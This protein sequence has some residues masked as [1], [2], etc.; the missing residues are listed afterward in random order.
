MSEHP[1]LHPA[2]D[3]LLPWVVDYDPAL[4]DPVPPTTRLADE[5]AE[6]EVGA[7]FPDPTLIP[8]V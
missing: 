4:A 5:P 7:D 2:D 8:E 1:V 3:P 6:V